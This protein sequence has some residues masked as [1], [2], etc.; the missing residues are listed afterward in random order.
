MTYFDMSES[1]NANIAEIEKQSPAQLNAVIQ[2]DPKAGPQ[3]V[4]DL[5]TFLPEEKRMATVMGFVMAM[6]CD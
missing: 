5:L 3:A 1:V 4:A 2:A 6:L